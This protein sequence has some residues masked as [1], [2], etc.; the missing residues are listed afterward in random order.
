[1]GSSL[2]S[3]RLLHPFKGDR[4]EK[5]KKTNDRAAAAILKSGDMHRLSRALSSGSVSDLNSSVKLSESLTCTLLMYSARTLTPDHAGLLIDH[6]SDVN[7]VD[8]LGRTVLHHAVESLGNQFRALPEDSDMEM[9]VWILSN[10]SVDINAQDSSGRTAFFIAVSQNLIDVCKLL[11]K[12]N[13]NY[14]LQDIEGKFVVHVMWSTRMVQLLLDLPGLHS[15]LVDNQDRTPLHWAVINNY[16]DICIALL[17]LNPTLI[18]CKDSAGFTALAYA[19]R[20]GFGD[21]CDLLGHSDLYTI[22]NNGRSLMHIAAESSFGRFLCPYLYDKFG[23]TNPPVDYLGRSPLHY[24]VVSGDIA[25]VK[26]LVE[27]VH[28]EVDQQDSRLNTSLH[29]AALENRFEIC[30]FLC[31]SCKA[32]PLL[33]DETGATALDS[34]RDALSFQA[35]D[36][37]EKVVNEYEKRKEARKSVCGVGN[38]MY[39]RLYDPNALWMIFRLSS[40]DY[41]YEI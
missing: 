2:S 16:K 17:Q 18:H 20:N 22:D 34:A 13:A 29:F 39:H 4:Q 3:S 37:L 6:G 11:L 15:R 23:L 32:N 31:E 41:M 10:T 35:Y 38:L 40:T 19:V 27:T 5:P 14:C 1:M 33:Q 24:S 25:T 26:Y 12:H 9:I 30:K 36:Y 8:T 21:L 28:C 7:A